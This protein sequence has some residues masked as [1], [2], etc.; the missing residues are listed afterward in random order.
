MQEVNPLGVFVCAFGISALAG[1]AAMLRS[2]TE[3][4]LT[5]IATSGL[6][7]GFLGLGISLIWYQ[8]FQDNIYFLIGACVLAGLG[9]VT[10]IDFVLAIIRKGGFSITVGKSGS[11]DIPKGDEDVK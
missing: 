4:N 8:Q 10:T 3:L 5:N 6:N 9:G 1:L 11:V 7:S 2:K